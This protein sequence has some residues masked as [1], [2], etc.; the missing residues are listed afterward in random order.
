MTSRVCASKARSSPPRRLVLLGL[1]ATLLAGC[2]GDP[3]GAE[4]TDGAGGGQSIGTGGKAGGGVPDASA[5]SGR[6]GSLEAE[7]GTGPLGGGG[8]T[9]SSDAGD[10][11][12]AT[13]GG[14]GG[15]SRQTAVVTS[16]LIFESAPF[17]S[18]HASTIA[19]TN[20]GIVAAWFGGTAEGNRDVG[21]W[22]SRLEA[23]GWTPPRQVADGT[24]FGTTRYPTWNPV[25]FRPKAGP[26]I[27]F[28]KVGSSP[29]TWW[30]VVAPGKPDT[31][32]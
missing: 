2:N 18:C 23:N 10:G 28:Y 26:L 3:P 9:V 27:L 16:E 15:S 19:E 20:E 24:G 6:G 25:L 31:I 30:G 12:G 5:M 1:T 32:F 7:G 4:G 22:M 11:A 21:I 17:A 8:V 14:G 13:D 29:S